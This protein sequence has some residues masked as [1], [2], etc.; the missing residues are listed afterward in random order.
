MDEEE[1]VKPIMMNF[2]MQRQDEAYNRSPT[3]TWAQRWIPWVCKHKKVR[4]THGDEIIARWYRRRVCMVCGHSLR[5]DLPKECFFTG[6]D[7]WDDD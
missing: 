3:G 2:V 7:H 1:Q 4:C 6:K 5:G